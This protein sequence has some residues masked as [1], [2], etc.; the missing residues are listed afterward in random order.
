MVC[1][2]IYDEINQGKKNIQNCEFYK[3]IYEKISSIGK[4]MLMNSENKKVA[5]CHYGK[6]LMKNAKKCQFVELH[7]IQGILICSQLD[8]DLVYKCDG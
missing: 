5:Y 8:M 2:N 4:M 6:W 1:Q 3:N 7:G